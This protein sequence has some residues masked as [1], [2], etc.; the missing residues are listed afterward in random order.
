[1][2]GVLFLLQIQPGEHTCLEEINLKNIT[3]IVLCAVVLAGAYSPSSSDDAGLKTVQLVYHSDT[4][5]YYL[6]CG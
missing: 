1:M 3:I 2:G 5:G 4:R 6:P